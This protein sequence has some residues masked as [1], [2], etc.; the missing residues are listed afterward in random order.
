MKIKNNYFY[1]KWGR[2]LTVDGVLKQLKETLDP[3]KKYLIAEDGARFMGKRVKEAILD[4][5]SIC[6]VDVFETTKQTPPTRLSRR[7]R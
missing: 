3:D 2:D 6:G 1:G 4:D 5:L 7:W